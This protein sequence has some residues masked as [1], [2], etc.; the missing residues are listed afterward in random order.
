MQQRSRHSRTPSAPG[1]VLSVPYART[2][3]E[4]RQ[5]KPDDALRAASAIRWLVLP[6]RR[7][8][9]HLTALGGHP[10]GVLELR[11]ERA[12]ARH[13]GPAVGQHF[14]VRAAEIDHRL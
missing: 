6:A 11:R 3:R 13:R 9:E 14:Y 2:N 5:A 4:H 10:D 8:G 1:S 7:D 12:V